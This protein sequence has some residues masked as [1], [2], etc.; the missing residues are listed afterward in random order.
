MSYLSSASTWWT[1]NL[2]TSRVANNQRRREKP[3][4]ISTERRVCPASLSSLANY[5][6]AKC[7]IQ[8]LLITSIRW[9]CTQWACVFGNTYA[10]KRHCHHF[11][12]KITNIVWVLDHCFGD[13]ANQ[14]F[15]NEVRD[16][17]FDARDVKMQ[18]ERTS[19]RRRGLGVALKQSMCK[20]LFILHQT[21]PHCTILL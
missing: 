20:N 3:F 12:W 11:T 18:E 13:D 8:R 21:W 2:H 9:K 1:T 6:H 10:G 19:K 16:G 14:E 15:D 17:T 7:K 4:I 5:S